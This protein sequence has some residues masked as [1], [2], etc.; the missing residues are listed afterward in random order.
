MG[1]SQR[2]HLNKFFISCEE[3]FQEFLQKNPT[4]K[5]K[6]WKMKNFNSYIYIYQYHKIISLDLSCSS[7]SRSSI[8]LKNNLVLIWKR[9]LLLH[10]YLSLFKFFFCVKLS[11]AC[12]KKSIM[13]Q[14][15]SRSVLNWVKAKEI[16]LRFTRIIEKYCLLYSVILMSQQWHSDFIYQKV[17]KIVDH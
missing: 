8:Y 17:P 1:S 16:Y 14:I 10:Y 11:L 15:L 13:Y 7:I 5:Y 2:F 4:H 6:K 3:F 9:L 12:L